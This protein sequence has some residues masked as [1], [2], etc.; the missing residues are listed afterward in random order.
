M[1]GY[2]Y[3]FLITYTRELMQT[4]HR[5][6][7][8]A[9]SH[10]K[11]HVGAIVGGV[12]GGIAGLIVVLLVFLFFYRARQRQKYP[13]GTLDN[14]PMMIEPFPTSE[15][16]SASAMPR[17]GDVPQQTSVG[18]PRGG[19]SEDTS[20]YGQSSTLP[21]VSKQDLSSAPPSSTS[22]GPTSNSGCVSTSFRD[23]V[24]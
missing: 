24:V 2:V 16:T 22:T 23:Y 19:R 4:A 18:V 7:S 1:T 3:L 12:I 5:N 11:S 6:S 10:S 8:S 17:G 21:Q 9:S 20:T 14:G 15:P 13:D